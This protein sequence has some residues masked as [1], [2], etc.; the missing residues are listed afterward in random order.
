HAFFIDI[1]AKE[2]R[3]V[4]LER[5]QSLL[6]GEFGSLAPALDHDASAFGIHGDDQ[7]LAADGARQSRQQLRVDAGAMEG[8][9]PHDDLVRALSTD[10]QRPPTRQTARDASSLTSSSF[11]PLPMAASRSIT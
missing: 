6:G 3:A 5:L 7:A 4:R 1:G 9:R 2:P 8:R 11:D 10:R